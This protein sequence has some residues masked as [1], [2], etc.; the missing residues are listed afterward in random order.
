[1]RRL[2]FT[3]MATPDLNGFEAIKLAKKY[4]YDG[5]DLRVSSS[6]GELTEN[7]TIR[8]I[9]ELKNAFLSEG[10]K[11]SGLLC[12]NTK[13]DNEPKSWNSMR[14]SILRNLEIAYE[15]GSESIRIFAGNPNSFED[16]NAYIRKTAETILEVLERDKTDTKILIQNHNSGF[17]A[18]ECSQVIKIVNNKRFGLVFSPDHCLLEHEDMTQ[19][20]DSVKDITGQFYIA[21]LKLPKDGKKPID[22]L[23]GKGDVEI[24][25]C[26]HA[27]G[28]ISFSGWVTFKWEK[29]WNPELE[30]ADVALPYFIHYMRHVMV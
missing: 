17:K 1:M 8:E 12:Y 15:L 27:L 9:H 5:V 22:V 11:P 7:S 21:D 4:G 25:R 18:M 28:G 29:I 3:T 20:L 2:S 30:P 24:E 13:G 16:P 10:I 26:Y 23:P 19:V 6:K 14:D